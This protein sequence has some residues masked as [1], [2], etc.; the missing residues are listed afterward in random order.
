MNGAYSLIHDFRTEQP[1]MFAHG[2]TPCVTTRRV[3]GQSAQL[4]PKP[5]PRVKECSN[6][7]HKGATV[8][9]SSSWLIC[10]RPGISCS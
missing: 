6:G 8:A 5:D 7:G 1:P 4:L 3:R 10:E 9:A 2:H